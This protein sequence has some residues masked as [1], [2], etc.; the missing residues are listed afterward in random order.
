MA[1]TRTTA[2]FG[3]VSRDA[4]FIIR[5]SFPIAGVPQKPGSPFDKSK[6]STRRLRQLWEQRYLDIVGGM[7]PVVRKP[8]PPQ[9]DSISSPVIKLE[10][11][12]APKIT[13]KDDANYQH[14]RTSGPKRPKPRGSS[15]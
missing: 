8:Y 10:Q 5:K 4:E 12:R 11:R 7:P 1:I 3:L 13:S 6:V 15:T 2:R 14:T 9:P